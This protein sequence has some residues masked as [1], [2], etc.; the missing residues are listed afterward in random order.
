MSTPAGKRLG[1]YE[2]RTLLGVGGM[3]EVYLAHDTQLLRSVALKLLPNS[4]R[5]MNGC[6]VLSKKLLR[7]LP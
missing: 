3:G 7:H 4:L 1:R 2:I 6:A 5:T